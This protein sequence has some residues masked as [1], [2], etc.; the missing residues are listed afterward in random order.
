MRMFSNSIRKSV[1]GARN[2]AKKI[3]EEEK[4]LAED[5]DKSDDYLTE[6]EILEKVSLYLNNS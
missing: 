4:R 1:I 5:A 2:E 3:L 6:A